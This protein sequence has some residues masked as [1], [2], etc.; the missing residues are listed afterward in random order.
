MPIFYDAWDF[1]ECYRGLNTTYIV[2]QMDN[3]ITFQVPQDSNFKIDKTGNIVDRN[4]EYAKSIALEGVA[5]FN[6]SESL[7]TVAKIIAKKT[8][9]KNYKNLKEITIGE[10]NKLR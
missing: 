8:N 1:P 6:S 5:I 4:I 7:E 9:K 10:F 3:Y 2:P